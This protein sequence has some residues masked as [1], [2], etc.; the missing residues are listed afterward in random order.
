MTVRLTGVVTTPNVKGMPGLL[1]PPHPEI[2]VISNR[3]IIRNESLRIVNSRQ[4]RERN[5]DG[6]YH[7]SG[8]NIHQIFGK[9]DSLGRATGH[10]GTRFAI[11]ASTAVMHVI[12]YLE[13]FVVM[14]C[15]TQADNDALKAKG[16]RVY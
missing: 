16:I 10:F 7:S 2:K 3:V 15:S 8:A 1:L 11:L 13:P 5:T 12:G 14:L 9:Y 4:A 6:N